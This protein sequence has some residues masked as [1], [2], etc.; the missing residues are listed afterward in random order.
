MYELRIPI[1]NFLFYFFFKVGCKELVQVLMRWIWRQGW[2]GRC[3]LLVF[4]YL[5]CKIGVRGLTGQAETISQKAV[6]FSHQQAVSYRTEEE[7]GQLIKFITSQD[8]DCV[9]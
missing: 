5:C 7:M 1:P 6:T 2:V 3:D 8:E 4:R 9:R